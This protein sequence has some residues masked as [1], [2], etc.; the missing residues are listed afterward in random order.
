MAKRPKRMWE[1]FDFIGEYKELHGGNPPTREDIGAH[2]NFSA[3]AADQHINR[4]YR[5]GRIRFDPH[6]RVVQ[7]GGK[8]E[9][10][11]GENSEKNLTF[12]SLN[13]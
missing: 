6:G 2:F 11:E 7:I 3:Q 4:L 8:Y 10:P 12:H 5:K 13:L 9:K 1:V